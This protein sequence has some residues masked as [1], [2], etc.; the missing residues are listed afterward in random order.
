MT[1][2]ERHLK[3]SR[4]PL[5][6]Y[7]QTMA[8]HWPYDFAFEPDVEVP[9]G[10][11]GTDPEMH[12]YLRRVSMAKIDLDR[13]MGELRQRFPRERFLIVH[14]GD[15]HPM[16][17]RTCSAS[18]PARKPRTWRWV[19]N[20]SAS[21]PTT[22]CAA[23]TTACR[24]CRPTRPWTCHISAPC[25]LEAAGVPLSDSHRARKRL[26]LLCNGRYHS[27][28]RRDEILLFHRRLIDSGVM[29]AR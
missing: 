29:A 16:A 23:S 5:F 8:A 18:T 1:E 3:S 6:M 2:M 12:E 17:T 7:I 25:M 9:G 4:K 28:K 26:M 20:R 21:S 22:P 24:R 14:Y 11:P 19:R 10:G 15:H 13:M 27:C